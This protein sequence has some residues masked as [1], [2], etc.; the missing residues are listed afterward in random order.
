M[1]K[2]IMLA[3][4]AKPTKKGGRQKPIPFMKLE[5]ITDPKDLKRIIKANYRQLYINLSNWLYQTNPK[6]K[7][8]SA[9]FHNSPG[10]N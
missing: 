1:G 3:N 5:F 9:A 7:I 6:H 2:T 4:L 10:M 8:K